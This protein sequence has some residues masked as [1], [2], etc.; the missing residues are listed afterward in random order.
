MHFR[1]F[2]SKTHMYRLYCNIII[3]VLFLCYVICSTLE[4]MHKFINNYDIIG[5]NVGQIQQTSGTKSVTTG[6]TVPVVNMLKYA[7]AQHVGNRYLYLIYS[8]AHSLLS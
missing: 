8:S 2:K 3:I 6:T 4:I 5:Q 1:T 7:L